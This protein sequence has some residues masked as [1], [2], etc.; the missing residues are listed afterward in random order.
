MQ[1]KGPVCTSCVHLRKFIVSSAVG[2]LA[3]S[4]LYVFVAGTER[5]ISL[6]HSMAEHRR[7]DD[8]QTCDV[9][10]MDLW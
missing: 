2:A 4:L 5:K 7:G 9:C 3:V 6:L 8:N 10:A 1:L